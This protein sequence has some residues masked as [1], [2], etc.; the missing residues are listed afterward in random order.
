MTSSRRWSRLIGVGVLTL[1]ACSEPAAG[2]TTTGPPQPITTTPG[3]TTSTI[4]DSCPDVFCV[5]YHIRPEATW[6]DG[7]PVVG[8]DFAYTLD[9]VTD[10][11]ASGSGNPGYSLITADRVLDDK[12]YMIA[13][14][15]VFSPWRTLFDIVLPAHAEYDPDA[16]GPVT[17]P[18]IFVERVE[19]DRIVL[20]RN[21][22]HTPQD[23]SPAGDVRQ[24]RFVFPGSVRN[25]IGDLENGAVDLIDLRPLDWTIEDISGIEGIDYRVGPGPFWEHVT[26]NHDDPLLTQR[27][28]RELIAL[29]IDREAILDLTVRGIDPSAVPLGNTVWMQGSPSYLD[30]FRI[31]HDPALAEQMMIDRFCERGDDDVYSCQGRRMSFI[32]ATSVGDPFREAQVD[33]AVERMEAI[34]VEIVPLLLTPSDLFSPEVIFGDHRVWQIISFSWKAAADPFLGDSTYQCQGT[35]PHGMGALNV[36]R[37]CREEVD[38]LITSTGA[39]L[40]PDERSRVYNEADR[41]Y[42]EDVAVIPLYQKPSFLAWRSTIAGPEL[43][44]GATPMWN[45]GSWS[46]QETVVVALEIEPTALVPLVPANDATAVVRSAM[47]QGAFS[48]TPRLEYVP[49]LVSGADTIVNGG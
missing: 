26:F 29:A 6:S 3:S 37:Y 16:P 13:M 25:M 30:Q 18:F 35:G 49:A 28:V 22:W 44:P 41:L 15:R 48:V 2:T 17:G 5:I 20:D 10:P 34:G 42:L 31:G 14:S 27:W 40:D 23:G 19:G 9:L 32:W 43:N 12:T 21:P 46:G 33:L 24:L 38:S 36:N 47:Y 7:A 11:L 8:A 45:V 39:I 1:A 4:D